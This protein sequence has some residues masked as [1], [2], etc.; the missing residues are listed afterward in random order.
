[1]LIDVA[2]KHSTTSIEILEMPN[3]LLCLY[4]VGIQIGIQIVMAVD[5]K[6]LR[7]LLENSQKVAPPV[8]LVQAIRRQTQPS[9][10]LWDV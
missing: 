8:L 7:I 6:Q 5:L 1:M 9:Q 4:P 3:V 2:K 10:G